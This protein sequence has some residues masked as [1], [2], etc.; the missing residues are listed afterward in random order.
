MQRQDFPRLSDPFSFEGNEYERRF[1]SN[2]WDLYPG[3]G[4]TGGNIGEH[5]ASKINSPS[6]ASIEG[7]TSSGSVN[8]NAKDQ[9]EKK[10]PFLR[11]N[12][13]DF[14]FISF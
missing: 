1:N 13:R 6:F 4:Y 10:D 9:Q 2:V 8:Q 7:S 14:F 5:M 11:G 3:Y 12:S